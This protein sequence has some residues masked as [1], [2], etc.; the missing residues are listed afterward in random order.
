[1]AS[2]RDAAAAR[3][4]PSSAASGVPV[5]PVSTTTPSRQPVSLGRALVVA[6]PV[7]VADRHN[8]PL[9]CRA[10]P[11][12][13]PRRRTMRAIGPRM[14]HQPWFTGVVPREP[15]PARGGRGRGR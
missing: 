12:S 1:L 9:D 3:T 6:E 14:V 7:G 15:T 8:C 10:A 13:S 11:S 2:Y 5:L 4:S